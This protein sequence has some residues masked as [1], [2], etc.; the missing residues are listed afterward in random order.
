MSYRFQKFTTIYPV[1][2][3]QFLAANPDYEQVPYQ[4]LYDR[5][6]NTRYGLANFY[7]QHMN[8]LGNEA[9]DLF[10]SFEPL[11]KM[12]A[13][14]NGIK[15]GEDHW[16]QDIVL[17]QVKVF[18]PDALYL[19][20]LYLFDQAFRQQL[21]QICGKKVIIVGWRAAP[22]PDFSVFRD[23]DIVLTCVPN[24]VRN[25]Q[26]NGANAALMPLAFEHTILDVVEPAENRDL[27]FTFVGSL[28]SA[29]G[30]WCERNLVVEQLMQFTPLQIW[31]DIND[32]PPRFIRDRV[33]DKVI[34]RANRF[35]DG[36]G[37]SKELREN[38]PLIRRGTSWMSDPTLPSLKQRYPGRCH[39]SVF[40]LKNF[41]V[42]A[43]SK[44]VFNSHG[45]CA[46]DYAGNIRLY[47]ATGMGACLL[48]DWK[49]NLP[50]LFEPDVEV[51]TYRNSEEGIEKVRYLLDHEDER[52]SIAVA[53]QRRTLRDHTFERRVDQLDEIIQSLLPSRANT[54]TDYASSV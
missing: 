22:T 45:D 48:T 38:V 52:R 26:R 44:I 21:R 3:R 27:D 15:Y 2:V 25:L 19:Q 14:E 8:S 7:A 11:Q 10:A 53:G 51:V 17:A 35:M 24:F 32:S 49:V 43:R 23:L 28:G 31:S 9:Q 6:V 47:E 16:L 33:L 41:E 12:W 30:F 39:E 5:F 4:E 37:V 20:D 50:D 18:Q 40:G 54:R 46:E 42:L 34:Y 29:N 13:K 1:F 36:V